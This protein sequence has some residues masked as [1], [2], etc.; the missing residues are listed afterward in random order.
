MQWTDS[1]RASVVWGLLN[2]HHSLMLNVFIWS[3]TTRWGLLVPS[4]ASIH[5][6]R[7]SSVLSIISGKHFLGFSQSPC[8]QFRWVQ[9]LPSSSP[10]TGCLDCFHSCFLRQELRSFTCNLSL[11][12]AG[13]EYHELT[14]EC[15]FGCILW[16]SMLYFIFILPN[17]F[18][19]FFLTVFACGVTGTF[20][21]WEFGASPAS[22]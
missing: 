19:I 20:T 12:N 18:S 15:C 22:F 1:Y 9:L 6:G 2:C 17:V 10:S 16:T 5:L 11:L 13:A 4:L 7:H 3:L 8:F 14:S 21:V